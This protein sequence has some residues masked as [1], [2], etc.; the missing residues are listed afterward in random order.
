M[1]EQLYDKGIALTLLYIDKEY[2]YVLCACVFMGIIVSMR[3]QTEP[4]SFSRIIRVS[5]LSRK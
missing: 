4:L 1:I 3:D 5:R 2:L